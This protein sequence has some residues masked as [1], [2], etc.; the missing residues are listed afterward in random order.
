M[1]GTDEQIAEWVSAA[2]TSGGRGGGQ[3]PVGAYEVMEKMLGGQ[4]G[5]LSGGLDSS[6]GVVS[7]SSQEIS[8]SK[9][10][11]EKQ[12]ENKELNDEIS[13]KKIEGGNL[14]GS[15][16]DSP[17]GSPVKNDAGLN[18]KEERFDQS[19][20]KIVGKSG[21][22]E[23]LKRLEQD[24]LF[25]YSYMQELIA[26]NASVIAI[27]LS[28]ENWLKT[29][30]SLRKYDLMVEQSRRDSGELISRKIVEDALRRL[31][32]LVKLQ[33]KTAIYTVCD[34]TKGMEDSSKMEQISTPIIFEA[35]YRASQMSLHGVPEWVQKAFLEEQPITEKE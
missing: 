26:K 19:K 8:T 25:A 20:V 31:S 29:S 30:E 4:V 32:Q 34:E 15:P 16:A 13:T 14:G 3:K 21:A 11:V 7:S 18:E 6:Q 27:K 2:N 24:E 23:A 12:V 28:R 35:M 1:N 22:A 33:L 9:I 5:G 17:T 10:E